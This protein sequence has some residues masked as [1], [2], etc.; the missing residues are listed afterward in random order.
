[1]R[2]LINLLNETPDPRAEAFQKLADGQ[3]GDPEMAMLRAQ[4]A[5]GGG[6]MAVCVE[7]VGDLTHRMAQYPDNP[8]Y[9]CGYE[10]VKPKVD[11]CLRILQSKYISHMDEVTRTGFAAEHDENMIVN[12]RF[13]NVPLDQYLEKV[14][15]TLKAYA[16]AHRKLRVYNVCQGHAREAA[17]ALGEQD[18][19]N[20]RRHLELLSHYLRDPKTWVE[21]ASMFEPG[22]ADNLHPL[23]ER[24]E[25]VSCQPYLGR[26]V[27]LKVW[28]NPSKAEIRAA[29]NQSRYRCLRGMT[30]GDEFVVWDAYEVSHDTVYYAMTGLRDFRFGQ[31]YVTDK[32]D[33]LT[34]QG[35]TE[36]E[37]YVSGEFYL[38]GLM[39]GLERF[40]G[41][42]EPYGM[43]GWG[44]DRENDG[45]VI[46]PISA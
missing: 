9:N 27:E 36:G 42:I 46:T 37:V 40:F 17:V 34:E 2:R 18:F 23:T 4:N 45:L 22:Y 12:A 31:V 8:L 29:L 25:V 11:R 30:M 16:D 10:L 26:T 28:R 33:Q 3:R 20:A 24:A 1:M 21:Y 15:R 13:K 35:W 5:L 41:K 43:L 19:Y 14:N 38:M 6:V 44:R 32:V 7:H 39:T